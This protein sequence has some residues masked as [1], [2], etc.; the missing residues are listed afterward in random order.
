MLGESEDPTCHLGAA[1]SGFV[2]VVA[3]TESVCGMTSRVREWAWR[4]ASVPE[5][6]PCLRHP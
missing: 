3:G 5:A 6:C 2:W 1:V 4:R